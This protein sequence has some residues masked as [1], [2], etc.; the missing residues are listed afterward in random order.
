VFTGIVEE[1]GIVEKILDIPQGKIIFIKAINISKHLSKGDS[2]SINGVC[3]T[4]TG[5]F[6]DIFSVEAVGETLKKT[7]MRDFKH[8]T[9][10][11]IERAI[12]AG[13]RFGGH[14]VLGHVNGIGKICSIRKVGKHHHVEVAIPPALLKY[15]AEEGSIA[16][17]GISLTVASCTENMVELN[18]IPYTYNT[19]SLQYKKIGD[20]V[21]IEVDILSKYLEKIISNNKQNGIKE[22]ILEKWGY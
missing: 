8:G 17:D 14:I 20:R 5:I 1:V 21:N 4:V 13:D 19:T 16:I 22:N 10:V 6:Q 9:K 15:V 11:N 3:Q 7:T 2:V 12:K 18:I